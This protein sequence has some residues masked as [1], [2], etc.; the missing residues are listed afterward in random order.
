MMV[1]N[2]TLAAVCVWSGLHRFIHATQQLG[3][4]IQ[5]YEK[6]L[7]AQQAAVLAG[8]HDRTMIQ[9]WK[10]LEAPK[11][12]GAHATGPGSLTPPN[13]LDRRSPT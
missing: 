11:V 7:L 8:T 3:Q 6:A 1:S 10:D 12:R 4:T 13:R 2:S 9:Y 5:N